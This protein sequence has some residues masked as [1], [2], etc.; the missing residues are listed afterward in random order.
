MY[1]IS[2]DPPKVEGIDDE[3][4]EPLIQREDDNEVCIL[5]SFLILETCEF[6]IKFS[7]KFNLIILGD[8]KKTI[9]TISRENFPPS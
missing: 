1:N 8:C 9:T 3:T 4:G 7:M 6:L 2:Y 5:L